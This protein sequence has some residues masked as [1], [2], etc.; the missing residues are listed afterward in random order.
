MLLSE[1]E[2][3]NP[4]TFRRIAIIFLFR[5]FCE[6]ER[7]IPLDCAERFRGKDRQM[8]MKNE[9]ELQCTWLRLEL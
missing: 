1:N 5:L 2:I 9:P 4:D 8:N 6:Q 3:I 7:N